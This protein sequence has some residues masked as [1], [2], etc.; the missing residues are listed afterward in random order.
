MYLMNFGLA[1]SGQSVSSK[2]VAM[3]FFTNP[4]AVF[5]RTAGSTSCLHNLRA[6]A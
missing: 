2:W 1:G 4:Q 5:W 6:L 3:L